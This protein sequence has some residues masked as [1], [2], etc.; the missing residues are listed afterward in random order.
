MA[1]TAQWIDCMEQQKN[2]KEVRKNSD[3]W[4]FEPV[5]RTAFINERIR[6][7]DEDLKDTMQC[8]HRKGKQP[9]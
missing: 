6:R 4:K 8:T 1:N 7:S 5:L 9:S 3:S 2:K